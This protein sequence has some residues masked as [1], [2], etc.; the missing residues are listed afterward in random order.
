MEND[1]LK[2][3]DEVIFNVKKNKMSIDLKDGMIG[4]AISVILSCETYLQFLVAYEYIKLLY[5]NYN[6]TYDQWDWLYKIYCE[7]YAKKVG[8]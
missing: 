1:L 5:I 6:L 4:K 7:H 3:D 8:K 2:I